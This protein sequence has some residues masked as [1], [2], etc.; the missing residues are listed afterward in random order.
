MRR[1][2]FENVGKNFRVKDF[3][4]KRLKFKR[5][6]LTSQEP[7]TK[8]LYAIFCRNVMI[9]FT[10]QQKTK[11]LIF[12]CCSKQRWISDNRKSETISMQGFEC[13][14]LSEKVY[15]KV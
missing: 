2:Y 11:I 4:R 14:S 6:D 3:V 12:S 13:A 1:K 9:Y 7:I 15:K 10:N 5:H 8:F